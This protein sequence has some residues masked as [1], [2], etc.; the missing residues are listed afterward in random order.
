MTNSTLKLRLVHWCALVSG[1]VYSSVA[2]AILNSKLHRVLRNE[3]FLCV[4]Q[5]VIALDLYSA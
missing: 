3:L 4:V 5:G 2:I 1:S